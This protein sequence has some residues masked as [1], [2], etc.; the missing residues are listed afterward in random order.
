MQDQPTALELIAAVREFLQGEIVPALQD[1]RL[2]FHALVAANVLSIVERE[3]PIEAAQLRDEWARLV[4]LDG[5]SAGPASAPAGLPELRAS[6]R[7][8]TEALC[9]R[10]RAGEADAGPWRATVL[11][12][13]RRSVE[14]K[15]R[16]NNPRYLE[17]VTR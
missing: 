3:L 9:A 16:V 13:A 7:A 8:R 15:L 11:D 17:R 12:H 2:R 10:I 14:E 4:A 5:E 1:H 6:V